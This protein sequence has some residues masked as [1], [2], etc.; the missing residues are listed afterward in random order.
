[1]FEK[2]VLPLQDNIIYLSL[3]QKDLIRPRNG[4]QVACSAIFPKGEGS[5][6]NRAAAESLPPMGKVAERSEVG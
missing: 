5:G 6:K 4:N 2:R 1:M 3:V